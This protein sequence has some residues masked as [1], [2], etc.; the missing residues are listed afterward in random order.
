MSLFYVLFIMSDRMTESYKDWIDQSRLVIPNH[1]LRHIRR[2]CK[3]FLTGGRRKISRRIGFVKISN[4]SVF[5][6]LKT[7]KIQDIKLFIIVIKII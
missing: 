5:S 6:C 1:L 7:R 3:G 2:T 4:M